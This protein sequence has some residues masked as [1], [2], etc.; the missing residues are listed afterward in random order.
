[1]HTGLYGAD[2][3]QRLPKDLRPHLSLPGIDRLLPLIDDLAPSPHAAGRGG[4]SR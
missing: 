2:D 4:K 3:F 1:V